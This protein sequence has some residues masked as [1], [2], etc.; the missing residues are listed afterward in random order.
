MM[1]AQWP[2]LSSHPLTEERLKTM[3]QADQLAGGP[4]LISADEW[5]ALK[6]ICR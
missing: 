3:Q 1:F 4:A 2:S 5:A 6:A